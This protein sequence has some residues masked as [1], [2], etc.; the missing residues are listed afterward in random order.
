MDADASPAKQF[1]RMRIS[2]TH[3]ETIPE[4]DSESEGY[5]IR[6][7]DDDIEIKDEEDEEDEEVNRSM[8]MGFDEAVKRGSP[9]R[10]QVLPKTIS[11]GLNNPITS[12][13]RPRH[14]GPRPRI[15]ERGLRI[16]DRPYVCVVDDSFRSHV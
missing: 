16:W 12:N 5:S 8:Q 14:S 3:H 10:K 13:L 1:G 6:L 2:A 15:R 4:S 9:T 11:S 7:S